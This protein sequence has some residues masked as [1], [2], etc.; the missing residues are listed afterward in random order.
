MI[1]VKM[2]APKSLIVF[3]VVILAYIY[4][5]NYR[6]NIPLDLGTVGSD[7][8][9]KTLDNKSFNLYDIHINKAIIFFK[10][11]TF[12]S[13][14]YLQFIQE[15]K[16]INKNGSTFIILLLYG[17]QDA[18]KMSSLLLNNKDL[19][20]LK[21]IIYLAN[22]KEVAKQY[23]V[24]SWPHFY[25]LNKDNIVIYRAKTPSINKISIFLRG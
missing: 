23:G 13:R 12:Y 3:L 21:D 16:E 10:N 4:L 9:I 5:F 6:N 11:N 8:K 1:S 14:H 19:S 15:L 22:V 24:K 18:N 25:L 7:F 17:P 20:N 2:L